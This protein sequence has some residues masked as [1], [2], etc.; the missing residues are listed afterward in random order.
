VN[1][2]PRFSNSFITI[3]SF[4]F[5]MPALSVAQDYEEQIT[6]FSEKFLTH[7]QSFVTYASQNV[8]TETEYNA[9]LEMSAIAEEFYQHTS[10]LGDFFLILKIIDKH[11]TEKELAERLVRLRIKSVINKCDAAVEGVKAAVAKVKSESLTTKA[12]KLTEDLE[13]LREVLSK[14]NEQYSG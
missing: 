6:Q 5:L 13:A 3:I 11:P 1:I 10:Y 2:K 7:S 4:L 12:N 14:I 9:A 8:N